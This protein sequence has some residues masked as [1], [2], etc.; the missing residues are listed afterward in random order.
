[1]SA[2]LEPKAAAEVTATRSQAM[3]KTQDPFQL[4]DLAQ[5]L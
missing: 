3:S 2:R 1:V 5:R 4:A